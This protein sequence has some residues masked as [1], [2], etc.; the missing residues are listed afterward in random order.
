MEIND[1]YNQFTSFWERIFPVIIFH[2]IALLLLIRIG[3]I[4]LN[5]KNKIEAYTKTESYKSNKKL[6]EEFQLWSKI[7]Y[8]LIIAFI[9]YLVVIDDVVGRI[10]KTMPEPIK[11]VYTPTELWKNSHI[12]SLAIMT[13]HMDST[14]S[15]ISYSEIS[16]LHNFKELQLEILKTK[17]PERYKSRIEWISKKT[18]K[19]TRYYQFTL[20]FTLLLPVIFVINARKNKL[21]I[22]NQIP[23]LLL[24]FLI[25]FA[26]LLYFRYSWEKNIESKIFAED[27]FI[28][29]S[30]ISEKEIP[31]YYDSDKVHEMKEKILDH[32][33]NRDKGNFW[34]HNILR[35]NSHK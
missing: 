30:L 9:I 29:S 17:F 34:I 13:I 33:D 32:Y 8:L 24:M 12:E 15:K 18:G 28:S 16:D 35:R 11:L 4:N 22:V 25:C 5:L 19:S 26:V 21:R 3:K 1:L 2:V 7:P 20:L 23:R 31:Y 10:Q 14:I 27:F 6:L